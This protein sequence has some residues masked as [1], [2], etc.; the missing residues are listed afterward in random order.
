MKVST[1]QI[2]K[3][4]FK[5]SIKSRHKIYTLNTKNFCKR[6]DKITLIGSELKPM[7]YALYPNSLI[8]K[9]I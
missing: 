7:M 2:V 3:L 9:F 1:N 4:I 6:Y 5:F 8:A